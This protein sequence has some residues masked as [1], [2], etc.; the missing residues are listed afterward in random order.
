MRRE[1]DCTQVWL[2][3]PRAVPGMPQGCPQKDMGRKC[4]GKCNGNAESALLISQLR[5]HPLLTST[6]LG[7]RV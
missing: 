3:Y 7:V 6:I 5:S 1:S 4:N 2:C